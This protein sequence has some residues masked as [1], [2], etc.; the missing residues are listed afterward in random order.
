MDE[1]D[2]RIGDYI[3]VEKGG[4]VIP[5]VTGVDYAAR[6]SSTPDYAGFITHCLDCGTKLTRVDGEAHWKCLNEECPSRM[7]HAI[8]HW[9][10]KKCMNIEIGMPRV[11]VLFEKG[12]LR[13]VSDLYKMDYQLQLQVL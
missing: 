3:F 7:K 13:D 4:E 12:I 8:L 6:D 11:K 10:D 9:C 5:K 2:I 1:L